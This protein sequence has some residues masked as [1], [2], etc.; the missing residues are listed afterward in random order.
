MASLADYYG[1]EF[2]A[3]ALPKAANL[4]AV[5]KDDIADA[6]ARATL[7]TGKCGYKKIEHASDLLARIRPREGTAAAIAT[8]CF[9]CW[10][11]RSSPDFP[12]ALV[13]GWATESFGCAGA[14]RRYEKPRS[15]GHEAMTESS[16][17]RSPPRIEHLKV[18]NFRALKDVEIADL[19]PLTVLIGPNGSGKSTVLDVFAFLA[20][21][22]E[23]GLG[24][25]WNRRGGAEEIKTR[26]EKEPVVI[27][28][29]CRVGAEPKLVVYRLEVDETDGAPFVSH[30]QLRWKRGGRGKAFLFLDN[31]K[32]KGKQTSDERAESGDTRKPFTLN[33]P[34]TLAVNV[35]EQQ[36][37][38]QERVAALR[39]FVKGWHLSHFSVDRA[40]EESWEGPQKRLTGKGDNL[41]NVVQYLMERCPKRLNRIFEL[42]SQWVPRVEEIRADVMPDGRL[43]LQVKDSPFERPIP[44]RFASDGTLKMLAYLV[45]LSDPKGP[46][47]IGIEKPEN[48][49]HPKLLYKLAGEYRTATEW[50]QLLVTTHSPL[51]LNALHPKEVRVLWRDEHGHTR[52]ERTAD[53]RGVSEFMDNGAM[54]GHLWTEGQFRVGDP[55]KRHGAPAPR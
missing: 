16:S 39:E 12:A 40:R 27:E 54:L 41:A 13:V 30:E 7:R 36:F 19:T 49:L 38:E 21:C 26:D 5:D 35:W 31:K 20:E 11:V 55:L 18:Q 10:P 37:G 17:D 23:N 34:D 53:L 50:A 24:K 9:R 45:L 25:A 14:P 52:V 51:F 15:A 48:F 2:A 33:S 32:G 46:P 29:K 22:F 42:L 8:A 4:E 3:N 28:L 6:L 1:R 47:F 44:A 43:R